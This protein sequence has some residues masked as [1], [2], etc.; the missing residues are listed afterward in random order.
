MKL[1]QVIVNEKSIKN[2]ALATVNRV[3]HDT[4]KPSLFSGISRTYQPRDDEGEKLPSESTKVQTTV[5]SLLTDAVTALIR[6]FNM[7]AT[8]DNANCLAR[9]NVEIGGV[10]ILAD[11]PVPHL[12]FLEKQL[13]DFCTLLTKLPTLAPEETWTLDGNTNTWKTEPVTTVR[14]KKVPRNHVKAEATDRHPAQVEVYF[15]DV[16]VGRWTTVKYS[17]A[18]PEVRRRELLARAQTLLEAIRRGREQAN[19][20]AAPEI[21]VGTRCFNFIFGGHP[22]ES[23]QPLGSPA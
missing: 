13:T 14:T 17:G 19:N 22:E 9:G 15:E 3:Y 18:I 23:W 8:K 10:N 21:E 20:T 1:N 4:Q 11:V 6:H 12:L 5:D 2:A 7:A 16:P